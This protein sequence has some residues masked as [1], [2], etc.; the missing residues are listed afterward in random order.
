MTTINPE[1][2]VVASSY[3]PWTRVCTYTYEHADH[4]RYTV[5]VHIDEFHKIGTTPATRDQRRR[6]LALRIQSH[7][8]SNPPDEAPQEKASDAEG[9]V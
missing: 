8:Q 9:P 2:Q 5:S 7:I 4:S 1:S 3:N 6:H